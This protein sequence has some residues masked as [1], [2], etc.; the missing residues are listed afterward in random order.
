MEGIFLL[1]S[2]EDDNQFSSPVLSVPSARDP[3]KQEKF[4]FQ[5]THSEQ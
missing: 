4:I 2:S 5:I 3:N 1:V